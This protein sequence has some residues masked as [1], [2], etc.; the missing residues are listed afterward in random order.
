MSGG[1]PAVLARGVGYRYP[2]GRTGLEPVE[3][4]IRPGEIVVVLGPNGSGKSTLLRLLATDL[5]PSTGSLTLLGR[6]V[7]GSLARIRRRIGYAPDTPVHFGVLSGRENAERFHA[8]VP[9]PGAGPTA[10][11]PEADPV[12]GLLRAFDLWEVRD[13]PVSEYSYGMKRKLLLVQSLSF[14]PRLALLDEPAVGLDPRAVSAL[15]D[16]VTARRDAGGCVIIASNEIREVPIWADRV[17]FLHRGRLV[18]EAPLADLL[19]RL[20]GHTRIEIDLSE[21]G[22]DPWLDRLGVIPGVVRVVGTPDGALIESSLGPEPLPALLEA[23]LSARCR[24]SDVRVRSPDLG[25]LFQALTGERLAP[26][27]RAH[28]KGE[29]GG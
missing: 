24:V 29:A 11:G 19:V 6:P 17:L 1:N 8:M 7:R 5:R 20:D 22:P 10:E 25:D 23:L 26:S 16:A 12:P 27:E 21:A 4:S 28:T 2:S 13:L 3:L 18:E 14:A 15:R 9:R